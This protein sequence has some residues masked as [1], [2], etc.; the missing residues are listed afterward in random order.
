MPSNASHCECEQYTPSLMPRAWAPA[1]NS[2]KK[3]TFSDFDECQYCVPSISLHRT[4]K[5][6]KNRQ[7]KN[8]NYS[9]NRSIVAPPDFKWCKVASTCCCPLVEQ[10]GQGNKYAPMWT[11]FV[12]FSKIKNSKKKNK[13]NRLLQNNFNFQN[14]FNEIQIETLKIKRFELKRTKIEKRLMTDQM[15]SKNKNKNSKTEKNEKPLKK[16]FPT[17][18]Y[19]KKVLILSLKINKHWKWSCFAFLAVP[20]RAASL[21]V[22]TPLGSGVPVERN[23]RTTPKVK[24]KLFKQRHWCSSTR[25]ETSTLLKSEQKTNQKIKNVCISFEKNHKKYP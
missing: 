18:F 24:F 16:T 21:I 8:V 17:H 6:N 11:P 13:I 20:A 12:F 19:I 5:I 25:E 7:N 4:I 9:H 10:W 2:L 14:C 23:A 1:T 15:F 3:R 22:A